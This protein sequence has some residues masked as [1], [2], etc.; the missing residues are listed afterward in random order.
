MPTPREILHNRTIQWPGRPSQPVDMENIRNF[1]ISKRQAQCDQFNKAHGVWALQ[2]LPPDQEVLFRSP[3]SDEYIPGIIIE[4]A[5]VPQSYFIKAPGKKYCRTREQVQPIHLNLPPPQQSAESHKQQCFS[6]PSPMAHKQQSF[7]GPS[8]L[9]NT[10]PCFARP[11]L[12]KSL[13]PRSVKGKPCLA[14]PSVLTGPPLPCHLGKLPLQIL[15]L[16]GVNKAITV[17]PSEEDLLLHMSTLVPLP[18]VCAKVE[19]QMP[20]EAHSAP[21]NPSTTGEEFEVESLDSLDSQTSTA[22]YS[23]LP[24][25]PITYNEAAL[26]WLQGKLQVITCN[27]LS[28]PFPSNSECSTDDTNGNTSSGDTSDSDGS[29]VEVAADSSHLQRESLTAGTGTDTPTS[30][31]VPRT[32]LQIHSMPVSMRKTPSHR[33][34]KI[35]IGIRSLQDH[36]AALTT[37]STSASRT[38]TKSS[39]KLL[40]IPGP[41]SPTKGQPGPSTSVSQPP[42]RTPSP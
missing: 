24:R 12:P 15:H 1:L 9:S 2:E 21:T 38:T 5:P 25:F 37:P 26:S 3:A 20:A 4:K 13:I 22:S 14:R 6:R 32:T 23:L 8:V 31:A 11:T 7:T 27:N 18:S 30:Q 40:P 41:S 34:S 33:H 17:F 10:K 36:A 19:T 42:D 39:G 28:I 16:P 29:P 35:P